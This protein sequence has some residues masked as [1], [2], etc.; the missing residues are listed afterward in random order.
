MNTYYELLG[1]SAPTQETILP[2][3][4]MM[5]YCIIGTDGF[6]YG[7]FPTHIAASLALK[8]MSTMLDGLVISKQY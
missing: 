2:K 6:V 7:T 5:Q 3:G 1:V 4:H 8:G